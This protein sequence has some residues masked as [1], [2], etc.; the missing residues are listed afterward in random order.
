MASFPSFH[1]LFVCFSFLWNLFRQLPLRE[2]EHILHHV[3]CHSVL[4]Y[5]CFAMSLILNK[6][7]SG[8][9]WM[10]IVGVNKYSAGAGRWGGGCYVNHTSWIGWQL[11][12]RDFNTLCLL[13]N[14]H[15][16]IM[17]SRLLQA[18]WRGC[19]SWQQNVW[20]CISYC[21]GSLYSAGWEFHYSASTQGQT[22]KALLKKMPFMANYISE[23]YLAILQF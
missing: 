14:N 4:F 1:S 18:K 11:K 21:T 16:V 6:M 3:S 17:L 12:C 2:A 20:L 9:K 15:T 10:L 13:T 8:W 5:R 7:H 23:Q 22:T 19:Q